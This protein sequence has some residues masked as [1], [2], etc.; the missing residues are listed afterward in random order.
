MENKL[1]YNNVFFI[2]TAEIPDKSALIIP[3]F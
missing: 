2:S 1:A 3:A